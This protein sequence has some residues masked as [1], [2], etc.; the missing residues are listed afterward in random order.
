L[1][2]PLKQEKVNKSYFKAVK[3]H[4]KLQSQSS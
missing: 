4:Q 2:K 1:E 3:L